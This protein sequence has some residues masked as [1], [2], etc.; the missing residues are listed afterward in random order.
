MTRPIYRP[1]VAAIVR[2]EEGLILV[3][4]RF[5][6]PGAWQFPQGGMHKSET[7]EEALE[8]EL[9]EEIGLLPADYR[10]VE[11]RGPYRYLFDNGRTKEGYHGQQQLYF[12]VDLVSPASAIRID[13]VDPEFQQ[14]RWIAPADFQLDWIPNFKREVYRKVFGDFFA[15]TL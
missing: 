13:T 12:L 10:I 8:R 1:N 5:G 9:A 4:E 14:V 15:I 6:V 7:A 2:N 11:K 3:A